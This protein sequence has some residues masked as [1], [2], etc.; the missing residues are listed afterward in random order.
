MRHAGA[1]AQEGR[2]MNRQARLSRVFRTHGQA[3]GGAAMNAGLVFLVDADVSFCLAVSAHF[4]THGLRTECY[5]SAQ[6]M[7]AALHS[8]T[9]DCVI[10]DMEGEGVPALE[11][12]DHLC[13]QGYCIPIIF[14]ADH[15]DPRAIVQAMRRGAHDFLVKPVVLDTLLE[16]TLDAVQC[17]RAEE[18]CD[19]RRRA[20][21]QRMARLTERENEIFTLAL[22][23]KS[24]KEISQVLGISHR[25][26]ETH[27]SHILD[28]LGV[29]SLLEL[30]HVFSALG[31]YL[32]SQLRRGEA[33]AGL[34]APD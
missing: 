8:L 1:A 9:P 16:R 33:G 18:D 2:A 32:G 5:R 30:A 17:A 13:G 26:V 4:R 10:L 28:K 29:A 31:S 12:Q 7:L 20:L 27:R 23:G 11:L 22:S 19:L 6:E 34:P 15:P 14:V 3:A 24:N 21:Q 25:T